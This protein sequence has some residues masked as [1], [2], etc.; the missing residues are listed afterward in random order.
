MIDTLDK[1]DLAILQLLQIDS[2]LSTSEIAERVNLSQAPCWRRIQRLENK[3]YIQK[4]IAVLNRK[5]L[6]FSLVMYTEVKLIDNN[7]KTLKEFESAVCK[8]PEIT[9]CYSM[10][11]NADFLLRIVTKDM[12]S[13]E[14]FFYQ[15]LSK[16]PN[17]H[18]FNSNVVLSELKNTQ[19]L[20]L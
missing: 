7:L 6:G 11:G 19:A 9:E 1:T 5:A 12:Q 8:Y 3:G 17:I 20:P 2:S 10:L 13:F 4:R 14:H 16:L 15:H 18:A